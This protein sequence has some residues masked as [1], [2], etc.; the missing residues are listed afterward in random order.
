MRKAWSNK[1]VT[2]RRT[3]MRRRRKQR[4]TGAMKV[5]NRRLVVG[6]L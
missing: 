1:K 4:S 3:N 5:I 6:M 2:A